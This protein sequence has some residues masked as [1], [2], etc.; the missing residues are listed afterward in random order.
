[1]T[2]QQQASAWLL[3]CAILDTET[4]GLYDDAEIVEISIIDENGGVLLD[5]LV[6]PLKPIP[7]EAT[8][9]HGDRCLSTDQASSITSSG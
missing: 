9:I 1:M 3:N 6:K 4:T 8:A 5:T 7:A 2:P